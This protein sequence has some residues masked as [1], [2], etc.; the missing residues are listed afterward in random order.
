MNDATL[1]FLYWVSQYAPQIASRE[2]R[3]FAQQAFD[4]SDTRR[5]RALTSTQHDEIQRA[6]LDA[7]SR[8]TTRKQVRATLPV[9]RRHGLRVGQAFL[10]HQGEQLLG[11]VRF[12]IVNETRSVVVITPKIRKDNTPAIIADLGDPFTTTIYKKKL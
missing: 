4:L 6:V 11:H 12:V 5:N 7:F 8:L 2:V 10:V 3:Q 9:G 1:A